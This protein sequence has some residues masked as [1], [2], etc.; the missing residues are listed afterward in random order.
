MVIWSSSPR[1]INFSFFHKFLVAFFIIILIFSCVREKSV[2][3][4]DDDPPA[5]AKVKVMVRSSGLEKDTAF[6]I[7][8]LDLPSTY[9]NVSF[10]Q[11]YIALNW[12]GQGVINLGDATVYES[13]FALPNNGLTHSVFYFAPGVIFEK[14][15]A[16]PAT[17][18]IRFPV[19]GDSSN[20]LFPPQTVPLTYVD[21]KCE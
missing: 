16:S 5:V 1:L 3:H 8:A 11:Y 15:Q 2:V 14:P 18:T 13:S 17:A 19:P 6:S 20:D 9:N 4:P 21:L 7:V 10:A 12:T